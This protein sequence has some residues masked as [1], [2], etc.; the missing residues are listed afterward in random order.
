MDQ[1]DDFSRI[2][3]VL[4]AEGG[5]EEAYAAIETLRE[6]VQSVLVA[7]ALVG[8]DDATRLAV[9]QAYARDQVLV[10]PPTHVPASIAF[11]LL[12]SALAAPILRL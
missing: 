10:I 11:L 12:L 1:N 4:D 5:S 8:G 6:S 9:K 2:D 7:N 3:V